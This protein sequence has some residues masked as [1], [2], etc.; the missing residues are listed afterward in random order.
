MKRTPFY[1]K[2][3][4]AGA[5]I[6]P[7]AD[8]EMPIEYMGIK[9]EHMAVRESVGVFDV[10]HMGEIWVKGDKALSFLQTITSNDVEKLTPG[11]AQYTCMP[12]EKGGIVDD[13]LVYFFE[14]DKYLLVVNAS[15]IEKDYQWMLNHNEVGAQIENVSDSIAQ[16]AVQGPKA[17]DVIQPLTNLDLKTIPFYHFGV[18]KL[19]GVENVIISATGYTGAG[20]FE[21]YFMNEDAETIWNAIFEAG[22]AFEIMPV[23]LGARD[24]LRL[25]MGY[26]LYGND[27]SDETSP[28][29]AGLGWITKFAE[30]KNF[31]SKELLLKQKKEGV[32][33]RLRGFKMIDRGIPRHEYRICDENGTSIGE[34][35]SGSIS[36]VL[37]VG[38][39]MGYVDSRFSD[40]GTTVY[41]EVRNKLLKA[42]IV[43]TP[44]I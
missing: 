32:S 9:K 5:K 33:R 21:L 38:I 20:G 26:C 27:L 25:E 35:T 4:A 41:V 3:T 30:H 16:L 36:P 24:T 6:H 12:N 43:K 11:Q 23:G 22:K 39:G 7:F 8:Y 34:V 10:S 42:E 13:L 1:T 29:E 19:A 18:G 28:I 40:F 37:L 15:N 2:H 31:I 17:F 44:F 14:A